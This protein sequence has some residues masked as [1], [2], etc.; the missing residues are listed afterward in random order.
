MYVPQ[1]T[2]LLV[3]FHVGTS[4]TAVS[5]LKYIKSD[6]K[7]LGAAVKNSGAQVVFS[8]VLQVRGMERERADRIKKINKWLREW[9]WEQGF[10]YYVKELT[11][12][13]LVFWGRMGFIC[14]TRRRRSLAASFPI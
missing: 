10:G 7:E 1:T 5:N 2:I 11:L 13:N 12:R 14:Q 3:L 6:Y 9:C 8:S 4:D